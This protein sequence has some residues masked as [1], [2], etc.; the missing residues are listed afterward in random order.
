MTAIGLMYVY[1]DGVDRS[2]E[3]GFDLLR[4]A[5]SLGSADA[6]LA[7]ALALLENP[8]EGIAMSDAI[9]MIESAGDS[10]HPHAYKVLGDLYFEGNALPIS[11]TAAVKWY[12][13]GAEAGDTE[14]QTRLG[15]MLIAG[16][17]ARID[18]DEAF[19][20]LSRAAENGDHGAMSLLGVLYENGSGVECSFDTAVIWYR[21]AIAAG[22]PRAADFL[23]TVPLRRSGRMDHFPPLYRIDCDARGTHQ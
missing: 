18:F 19:G 7:L 8:Q 17:G 21:R 10:G 2:E 12:R 4:R 15:K 1:G 3:K 13:K 11:E 14:S 6:E 23:R 16:R 20:W 5:A 9:G 22:N